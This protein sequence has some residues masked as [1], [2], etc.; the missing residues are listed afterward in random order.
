MVRARRRE[1]RNGT[2][3]VA[4]VFLS[5]FAAAAWAAPPPSAAAAPAVRQSFDLRVPAAP[6]PVK[7]AGRTVLFY[8]LHFAS[9]SSE[10]LVIERVDIVDAGDGGVLAALEGGELAR[11]LQAMPAR[12]APAEVPGGARAVLY[13]ELPVGA[14]AAPTGLVHRVTSRAAGE[15]GAA[16]YLVE[17][18]RVTPRQGAAPL[19]S[20]PLRGGP[21][22]AVYHPSV[23]RGHRRYIYATAGSARVPGR[24]AVDWIKL[25]AEG[26]HASGDR[27]RIAN[28]HGYGAEVLAVADGVVAA[29]RDDVTESETLAGHPDLPLAEGSGNYVSLDIGGGRYAFYEHLRPGSIQVRAGERVRR[30]QPIAQVGFT[31]H[32][33]GPHLHFHVADANS[34]LD[35]EG[36]PFVIDAFEVL[37]GYTGFD[38]TADV[39]WNP[40]AADAGGRRVQ[41]LPPPNAVVTF[42][43][44]GPD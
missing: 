8:E 43:D 22:A 40:P 36:L 12:S 26:R 38:A 1:N 18:A 21:W 30:G 31:G 32:S 29:V 7:V 16:A 23:E 10:T 6:V 19:L 20:P 24:H 35:A 5:S 15:A 37:G 11:R 44:A 39:P 28:W 41:E 3:A 27:D 33:M 17:G 9:Y 4:V 25:D 2:A 42:G 13:V 34:L 14:E